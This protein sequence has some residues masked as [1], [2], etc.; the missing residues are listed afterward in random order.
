MRS[1]SQLTQKVVII[2]RLDTRSDA[3]IENRTLQQGLVNDLQG[4]LTEERSL[5]NRHTV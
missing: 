5:C 3:F 4:R 2:S 1:T